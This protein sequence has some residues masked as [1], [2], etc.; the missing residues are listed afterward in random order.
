MAAAG[1]I[2]NR[3]I[4]PIMRNYC[5]FNRTDF[6][7]FIRHVQEVIQD[8]FDNEV[9]I[10]I[11]ALGFETP[12]VDPE[13]LTQV[14]TKKEWKKTKELTITFYSPG[15]NYHEVVE[16]LL[17]KKDT[18]TS[19]VK[20]LQCFVKKG[21][22]SQKVALKERIRLLA[23]DYVRKPVGILI[24]GILSAIC[25]ELVYLIILEILKYRFNHH[26][27]NH[28]SL[29]T[30]LV[31]GNGYIITA[32]IGFLVGAII[33]IEFIPN[34]E[35]VEDSGRTNWDTFSRYFW[36]FIAILG[37]ALAAVALI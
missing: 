26:S 37:L 13:S 14:L 5:V 31:H 35:F 15:D 29:Y 16:L 27:L 11:E 36:G 2:P 20:G 25:L 18:K 33:H 23:E 22:T 9:I 19:N 8:E 4:P 1:A 12:F 34:I 24:A 10:E 17:G 6:V 7:E 30:R 28:P 21:T 3:V 32:A